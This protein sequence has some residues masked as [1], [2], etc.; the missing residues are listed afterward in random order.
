[1]HILDFETLTHEAEIHQ[2]EFNDLDVNSFDAG[3][4]SLDNYDLYETELLKVYVP[5]E[6]GCYNAPRDEYEMFLD[7]SN[8]A[9]FIQAGLKESILGDSYTEEDLYNS[10]FSQEADSKTEGTLSDGTRY[11]TYTSSVD[12]EEYYY[13]YS[14]LKSDMHYFDVNIACFASDKDKLND[15]MMDILSKIRLK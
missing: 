8:V 5:K 3:I 10:I 4:A 11:M 15:S 9:V 14:L 2:E 13:V 12:G 1:M 6:L 7:G